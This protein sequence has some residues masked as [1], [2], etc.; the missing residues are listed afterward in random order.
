MSGYPDICKLYTF[1][2]YARKV[3][4]F[5]W[6]A[7]LGSRRTR[8]ESSSGCRRY[9]ACTVLS[10]SFPMANDPVEERSFESD[11]TAPLFAF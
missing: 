2:V 11:I 10:P 3:T 5:F 7:E 9:L 8:K 1:T 6:D 4:A